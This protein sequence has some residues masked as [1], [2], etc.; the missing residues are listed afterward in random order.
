MERYSLKVDKFDA[1]WGGQ[2]ECYQSESLEA[3]KYISGD[4]VCWTAA[5]AKERERLMIQ[6]AARLHS[7]HHR[8]SF[9]EKVFF[10]FLKYDWRS[11]SYLL[12]LERRSEP[13]RA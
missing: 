8:H 11:C 7:L 12:L 13:N 5:G 6:Q 9:L 1:K 10:S 4:V 3:L 2:M